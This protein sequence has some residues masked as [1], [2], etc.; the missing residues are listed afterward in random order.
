MQI[1]Q[2]SCKRVNLATACAIHYGLN[3]GMVVR[4]LKGKLVGE[5]RD[6]DK[7]LEK[8]SPYINEVDCKHIKWIINQGCWSNVNFEEDY[9]NKHMVLQKGDQQTFLQFPEVTAKAMNKEKKNSHV[10][11]FRK[12]LVHFLPYC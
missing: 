8:V 5:S 12:W 7:I 4:Y 3:T 2:K 11:A 6:V 9:N 1:R 10:I